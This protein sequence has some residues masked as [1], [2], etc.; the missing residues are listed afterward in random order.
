MIRVPAYDPD[1]PFVVIDIGNSHTSV[2][3]WHQGRVK[4]PLTFD[5]ANH[6]RLDDFLAAHSDA[7]PKKTIAATVVSSVV[8]NALEVFRE[9]IETLT[10]KQALVVG[11]TIPLPLDVAV[12]DSKAVGV[13]R[14]CAAAAA[15]DRIQS[16]C[17]VVD[18]GTAVTV[19]LVD[20]DG[21]FLGGAILPGLRLQLRALHE[22]TAQLPKV[23][24]GFPSLPYGTN[25]TEAIQT[26][27]CR[28]L[29]GAVRALVEAY[30]TKLNRWPQVVATGGDAEFLAPHCDF[31]DTLASN[32]VLRGIGLSFTKFLEGVV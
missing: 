9:R 27:V 6:T 17:T 29:S 22:F 32:L 2:A 16:G 4:T 15:F 24:P 10:G 8:P 7:M 11:E 1:A 20:D 30:A 13:D 3:T 31:I 23:E 21:T 28:G 19:D 25:T 18:F 12:R 26:G 5:T 14:V